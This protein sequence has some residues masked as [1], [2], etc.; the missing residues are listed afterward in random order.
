LLFGA[1]GLAGSGVLRACLTAPDVSEVRAVVRRGTGVR[2][3]KLREITHHNYLEFL[4]LADEF[5]GVDACFFCLG[6]SVRQAPAEADYRRIHQAFPLGAAA[7]LSAQSRDA[8]FH[9]L[10]GKGASATSR[11]MWARVKAEA[12]RDLMNQFDAVCWRPA[13][14]DGVP[15]SAEPAVLAVLR[16]VL[17]TAFKNFRPMYIR[18]DDIGRAMLAATGRGMRKQVLENEAIRDLADGYFAS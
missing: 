2:D 14:I 8:A 17:R 16:P 4:P 12:E 3:P 15:P 18:N 6:A 1:T 7:M 13:M 5:A 10:S 11:W 9:Y